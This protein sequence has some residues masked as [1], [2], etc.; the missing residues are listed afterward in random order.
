M[1]GSGPMTLYMILAG[2]PACGQE[3][4]HT[5]ETDGP[6]DLMQDVPITA[7]YCPLCGFDVGT[8]SEEWDVREDYEIER[9]PPTQERTATEGKADQ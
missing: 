2:C 3:V 6:V 4:L 9:V 1:A 7:R 5:E 8:S